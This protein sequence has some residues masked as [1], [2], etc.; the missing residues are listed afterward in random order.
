MKGLYLTSYLE[1]SLGSNTLVLS[2]KAHPHHN[3]LKN[4]V[5]WRYSYVYNK[6]N[7]SFSSNIADKANEILYMGFYCFVCCL[8][9]V[10]FLHQNNI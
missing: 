10:F 1:L 3:A 8:F 6:Y 5:I 4:L 2:A 7:P 9:W